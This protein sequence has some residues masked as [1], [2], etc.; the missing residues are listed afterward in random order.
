MSPT[1]E[2]YLKW[3]EEG[4]TYNDIKKGLISFGKTNE[5]ITEWLNLI[6]RLSFRKV[7]E[8]DRNQSNLWMFVIGVILF[9]SGLLSMSF[10]QE[11]WGTS[12]NKLWAQGLLLAILA[13]FMILKGIR[14]FKHDQN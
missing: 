10:A 4:K 1:P 8:K 11:L 2:K 5:E 13:A 12:K 6:G 14:Y 9:L 3:L 7:V